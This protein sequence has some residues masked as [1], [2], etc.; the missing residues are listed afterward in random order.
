ME[1]VNSEM[2]DGDQY[3]HLLCHIL[4]DHIHTT[5]LYRQLLPPHFPTHSP[6]RNGSKGEKLCYMEIQ[7]TILP[8]RQ[9]CPNIE[10]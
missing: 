7:C 1:L 2:C 9:P 3:A 6:H 8:T 10:V 5:V 4:L